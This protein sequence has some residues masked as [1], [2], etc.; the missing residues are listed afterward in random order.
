MA[1]AL[2]RKA[3][4]GKE[5]MLII[6]ATIMCLSTPTGQ[7]SPNGALIYLSVF[8]I[9]LGIGVGCDHPMSASV[10]TDRANL[11]KRGTL[12][13]YIFANQVGV[14]LGAGSRIIH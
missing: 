10:A 8:R 1:D 12:L 3:I 2:G 4:Y 14:F 5:L 9:V 11:R 13:A 6:F 7:L